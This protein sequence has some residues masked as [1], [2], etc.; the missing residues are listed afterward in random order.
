MYI[1]HN[2]MINHAKFTRRTQKTSSRWCRGTKDGLVSRL[3]VSGCEQGGGGIKVAL[4]MGA[5]RLLVQINSDWAP[6]SVL[7][8]CC[9]IDAEIA[10]AGT[11][12]V[13]GLLRLIRTYTGRRS[14][15]YCTTESWPYKC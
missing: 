6:P 3:C 15:N 4:L 5:R 9:H 12:R 1:T 10:G 7:I 2:E 13:T 14:L 8:R 11:K